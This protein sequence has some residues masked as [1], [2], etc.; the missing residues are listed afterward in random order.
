[1]EYL[2]DGGK[3]PFG[4]VGSALRSRSNAHTYMFVYLA[5]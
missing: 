5:C 1:M 4:G 2:L 3:E